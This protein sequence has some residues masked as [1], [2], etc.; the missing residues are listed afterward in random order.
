MSST[1]C[2]QNSPCPAP[3]AQ[4]VTQSAWAATSM[5]E[6]NH[7]EHG[8]AAGKVWLK[9]YCSYLPETATSSEGKLAL[10][11]MCP[12]LRSDGVDCRSTNPPKCR[13]LASDAASGSSCPATRPRSAGADL[14]NTGRC[15]YDLDLLQ[16]PADVSHLLRSSG[17][18]VAR[19]PVRAAAALID[20]WAARM[21]AAAE[22]GEP[23][24]RA[25]AANAYCM[26]VKQSTL[27]TLQATSGTRLDWRSY[28]DFHGSDWGP[29][30]WG[31]ARWLTALMSRPVDDVAGSGGECI[32]TGNC[33][34][35]DWNDF[36]CSS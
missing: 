13:F 5:N 22:A 30:Y 31:Q 16:T 3:F 32:V 28:R 10:A 18:I 36:Y 33:T 19:F 11:N 6:F 26:G 7:K 29:I 34:L 17:N 21:Q 24:T 1:V 12:A 23:V 2:T 8:E 4:S 25:A 27:G 9:P 20:D 14:T 15:E 35:K